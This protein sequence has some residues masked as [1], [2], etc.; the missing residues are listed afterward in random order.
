MWMV[1]R[2]PLHFVFGKR[3]FFGTSRP[4]RRGVV[5]C[6]IPAG[7]GTHARRARGHHADQSRAELLELFEGDATPA[8][9][10][11]RATSTQGRVKDASSEINAFG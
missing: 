1:L 3:C 7:E 8:A 2:A 4:E 11:I 9:D 6:Q 10:L 5:V